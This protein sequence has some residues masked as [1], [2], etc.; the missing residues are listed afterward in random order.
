MGG[1]HDAESHAC[2]EEWHAQCEQALRLFLDGPAT[3]MRAQ[4][5]INNIT[6]FVDLKDPQPGQA[7]RYV[8]RISNNGGRVD[9]VML[10]IMHNLGINTYTVYK[11]MIP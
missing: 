11:H 10:N 7:A 5:G 2:M 3:F 6:A 1:V 8:L 9:K 4:G